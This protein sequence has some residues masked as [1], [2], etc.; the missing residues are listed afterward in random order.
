MLPTAWAQVYTSADLAKIYGQA[1]DRAAEIS[2]RSVIAIVDRDGR[3]LLVLRAD[4]STSITPTE[5][6]IAIS[7]AG[8][9]VALSSN[10]HAFSSRTAGFIIQQNFP[11]GVIN[12]PPGPLVGVGF[13]NLAFSDVN[14]FRERDGRRIPGTRLYGSPGGV[15]LFKNGIL[16]AG[17]GVTGDGTEEED[18]SNSGPDTDEAVALSGQIGYEPAEELYGSH[19]FLDG[20]RAAYIASEA[21]AAKT[22]ST[23]TLTSDFAVAPPVE[24]PSAVLGGAPGQIRAPIRGDPVA[25]TIEGQA[26]L[27][28][29]EVITILSNAAERTLVT[30]AG[31]RLPAGRAAQ[32]FISV[33]N[34]PARAGEAPVVLGTFRTTDAT[35]FSWD[36]SVQKA[37]TALFFSNNTRAYSARTVG[38]LAQS[39]YPPG[40]Q[41]Q[42]PGPF[43]GLQE[44]F[45]VPILTGTGA[46]NGNLPNGIT[47][48]P[49][50]F[51]L[52]RNGV[53]IGAIGVSGDG[54]EQDDLIAA[55][56]TAGLQP[57]PE[58]RADAFSYLGARLPYAKFPRD[59]ELRPNVA[60]AAGPRTVLPAGFENI[61]A[62]ASAAGDIL[63]LSARSWV[64]AG[65]PLILGFVLQGDQR[66]SMLLRGVGPGLAA[67]AV[68]DPLRA[69]TTSLY[70][71]SGEQL[72]RNDGWRTADN[73]G[74]IA[75]A[76]ASVGAFSLS[77][78]SPDTA[79]LTA[80]PTGAYTLV[81]GSRDG[82]AGQALAEVY[83]AA[84]ARVGSNLKNVSIRGR[85]AGRTQPLTAGLVV[86]P[87]AERTLLIRGVGPGL[88]SFGIES[89]VSK[90]GLRLINSAG[91]T[92]AD[93]ANWD[94]GSNAG[95]I[96]RAAS[97]AGA[98]P[99]RAGSADMALLV[100][101]LPGAYTIEV[102][103][104]DGASGE[105]L[106]EVYSI[107]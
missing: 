69:P 90:I 82:A 78:N 100:S 31:I 23:V 64:G 17:I 45:S 86:A 51:P 14:Y 8:T 28:R 18:F 30:R 102:T 9:A 37:R 94:S 4:R 62:T 73:A 60:P 34:N 25:G 55:S 49:G 26:R 2:P 65:S 10:E 103:G 1:A 6:A 95:E 7:K 57:S 3:A 11:P 75:T 27:S 92:I 13:S 20:I 96:A 68:S 56:G 67:L 88:A 22:A 72:A 104:P 84:S 76:A 66:P 33:V 101:V 89:S 83:D 74:D 54:I 5:R 107:D 38:F 98:F 63:N 12:R 52:Y 53:L 48:F 29:D 36:V 39:N 105:V 47:I 50:G 46:I 21:V 80:L 106:A 41:N 93:G 44:R 77:N 71:S 99:L 87:G 81:L 70:A 79:V 40:L 59:A 91:Q 42:P 85:I 61:V 43:N 15:P 58:I 16:F 19:V 35:I 97:A 32:V 24:W